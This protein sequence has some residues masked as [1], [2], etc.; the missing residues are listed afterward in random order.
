MRSKLKRFIGLYNKEASEQELEKLCDDPDAG[1]KLM[2]ADVVGHA[3]SKV[4]NAVSD[5]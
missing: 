5:I 1:K 3:H 4:Q 2:Q